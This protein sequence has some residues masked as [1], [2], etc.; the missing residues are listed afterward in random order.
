MDD[1]VAV[2]PKHGTAMEVRETMARRSGKETTYT[3][4]VCRLCK[5][6]A[7]REGGRGRGRS[8]K[9]GR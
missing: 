2:C 1:E 8:R 6:E 3:F 9:E 5:V 7:G 4:H